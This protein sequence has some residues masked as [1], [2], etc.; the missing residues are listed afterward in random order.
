[1]PLEVL[2]LLAPPRRFASI[3]LS[4][5]LLSH[6]CRFPVYSVYFVSFLPSL[7]RLLH[8]QSLCRPPSRN[9]YP[10]DV[11]YVHSHPLKRGTV[12]SRLQPPCL[13]LPQCLVDEELPA[14]KR[15]CPYA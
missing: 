11:F 15:H 4:S 2:V 12:R 9:A 8:H 5:F 6:S 14:H 7:L 10:E 1:M 13:P 3:P